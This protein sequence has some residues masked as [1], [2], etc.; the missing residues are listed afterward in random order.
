MN[1]TK[2]SVLERIDEKVLRV[3]DRQGNNEQDL[4]EE[5]KEISASGAEGAG[6]EERMESV[7]EIEEEEDMFLL[8]VSRNED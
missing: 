6:V 3:Q 7:L 4:I 1:T 8:H 5:I 2:L